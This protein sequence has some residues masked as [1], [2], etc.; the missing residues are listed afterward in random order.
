M[1]RAADGRRT[2]KSM[3]RIPAMLGAIFLGV[4]VLPATAADFTLTGTYEGFFV[5]D[6]VTDGQGGAFGRA[7]TMEVVQSG[8]RIDMRN[9]VAVDA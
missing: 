8:D 9:T 1:P 7:M 2:V 3:L 4:A 5:C 6:D